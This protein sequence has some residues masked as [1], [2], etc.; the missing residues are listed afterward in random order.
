MQV[1]LE[2]R[3]QKRTI[4]PKVKNK[5]VEAANSRLLVAVCR[6]K[7]K[8]DK[9]NVEDMIHVESYVHICNICVTEMC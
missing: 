6:Q 7:N 2:L 9:Q 1:R 3:K 4:W 5:N 8:N